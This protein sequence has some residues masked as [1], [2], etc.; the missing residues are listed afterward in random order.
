MKDI[1]PGYLLDQKGPFSANEQ[2]QQYTVAP[3]NAT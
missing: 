3:H 2:Q 1:R